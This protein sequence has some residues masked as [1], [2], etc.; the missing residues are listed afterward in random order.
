MSEISLINTDGQPLTNTTPVS[1]APL[2]VGNVSVVYPIRYESTGNTD[3]KYNEDCA[4]IGAI[5]KF[6]SNMTF[7]ISGNYTVSVIQNVKTIKASSECTININFVGGISN[8]SIGRITIPSGSTI[9]GTSSLQT[10]KD[11]STNKLTLNIT[12]TIKNADIDENTNFLTADLDIS[13]ARNYN[14]LTSTDDTPSN[15]VYTNYAPG[16]FLTYLGP[17]P[18]PPPPPPT[19]PPPPWPTTPQVLA[20]KISGVAG[21]FN[22]AI[23]FTSQPGFRHIVHPSK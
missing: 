2:A 20:G 5:D 14:H 1:G 6:S 11:A 18:P 19:P 13:F 21:T 4:R 17:P 7:T 16:Q 22:N 12:F 15:T 3:A 8:T 10:L 9:S 23:T